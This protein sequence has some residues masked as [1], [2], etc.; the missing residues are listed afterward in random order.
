MPVVAGRGIRVAI[1]GGEGA[2]LGDKNYPYIKTLRQAAAAFGDSSVAVLRED[3][4]RHNLTKDAFDVVFF[5][6]GSGKREFAGIGDDGVAAVRAFVSSGGGY[7][8][9]CAGAFLGLEHLRFY[10][11]APPAQ[12]LGS[13]KVQIEFTKQGF[14][15]YSG[16][17]MGPPRGTIGNKDIAEGMK[18]LQEQMK[19]PMFVTK[20]GVGYGVDETQKVTDDGKGRVWLAAEM[21]PGGLALELF[22]S[23]P[24]G[25]RALLVAKSSNVQEMFDKV[26][27]DVAL[28][29]IDK[30][31]GGPQVK[32]R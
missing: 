21:S 9:T 26:N 31:F 14:K 27:W 8:G 4:I 2:I 25:K 3:G 23:V 1:Y 30:T 29:N 5:P 32:Q 6:G 17:W 20:G 24:Y 11:A 7:I 28:A 18:G 15:R 12:S 19:N 10:G 13:G 16:M 22:K